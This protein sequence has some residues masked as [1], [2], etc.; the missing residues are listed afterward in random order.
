MTATTENDRPTMFDGFERKRITVDG[1]SINL[2]VGGVGPPVLLLHGYPQTLAMWYAVAPRL[3]D[4]YTVAAADLRGYGDS[5]SPAGGTDHVAYSK[6]TM[7]NDQVGIMDALGFERFAVIGHDRGGRVGHR[8]ALD[9]PDRVDR[10]AVLD[11]VP[12]LKVFTDLNQGIA[13]GYYHWFFLIQAEPFPEQM[14]GSQPLFYLRWC[15]ARLG[16]SL[17]MF[18]T[19]ALAEYER[20]FTPETI[21]ASCE[22]YRAAATIDLDHDRADPEARVVCPTLALWGERG[23]IAAWYDVLACWRERTDDVSGEP[24]DAGHFL[25]EEQPADVAARLLAFLE[26]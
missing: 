26:T 24:V 22:D 25:V 2:V 8:L 20:C 1:V 9:Y 6:R 5:D 16:G 17:E 3:A 13:T 19:R 4:R 7:A 14:I 23:R 18:D 21:H 12:T 10:L 11:I 15:L